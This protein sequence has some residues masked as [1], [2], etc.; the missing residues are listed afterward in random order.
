MSILQ[1]KGRSLRGQIDFVVGLDA[2]GFL[3]GP[4]VALE[5]GVPFVPVRKLKSIAIYF[6]AV[7]IL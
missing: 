3:M 5:A 7:G 4:T 1:D 2:R 6:C